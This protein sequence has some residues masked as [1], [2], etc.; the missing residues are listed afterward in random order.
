MWPFKRKPTLLE[1]FGITPNEW[2]LAEMNRKRADL[3][4]PP[5]RDLPGAR[6]E[7]PDELAAAIERADLP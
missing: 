4:L 3:G 7:R 1:R 5:L 6:T 2:R